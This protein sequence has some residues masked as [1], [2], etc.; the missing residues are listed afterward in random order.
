[1]EAPELKHR[2][3]LIWIEKQAHLA[4]LA[5]SSGSP[6]LMRGS[7]YKT[8]RGIKCLLAF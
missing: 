6:R 4:L 7:E 1:M 5:T 2:A 8:N 3:L